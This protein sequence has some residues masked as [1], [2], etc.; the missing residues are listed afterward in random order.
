MDFSEISSITV[1]FFRFLDPNDAVS[2]TITS[3][4]DTIVLVGTEIYVFNFSFF[5]SFIRRRGDAFSSSSDW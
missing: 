3:E 4:V 5:F 2:V 1:E